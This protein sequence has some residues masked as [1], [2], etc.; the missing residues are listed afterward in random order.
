MRL[1]V[2]N[3]AVCLCSF[4]FLRMFISNKPTAKYFYSKLNTELDIEAS[5]L[6]QLVIKIVVKVARIFR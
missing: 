1:Q 2:D 5:F 6:V 4:Q 3:S